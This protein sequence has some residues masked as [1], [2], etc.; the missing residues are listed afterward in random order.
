M[1]NRCGLSPPG[2]SI[3]NNNQ[4]KGK[5]ERQREGALDY[6]WGALKGIGAISVGYCRICSEKGSLFPRG[7]NNY[8]LAGSGEFVNFN[9]LSVTCLCEIRFFCRCEFI[10][11]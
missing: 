10:R 5:P 6:Y 2:E 4:V 3:L 7:R 9:H 1:E 8:P 11:T